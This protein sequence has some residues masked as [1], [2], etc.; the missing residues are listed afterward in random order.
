MSVQ[1]GDQ[2]GCVKVHKMHKNWRSPAFRPI[3]FLPASTSLLFDL[4]VQKY[5][6][7]VGHLRV[8]THDWMQ[9]FTLIQSDFEWRALM[10]Q[11]QPVLFDS[12][13]PVRPL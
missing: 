9:D 5:T 13:R 2:F 10:P 1:R 7:I 6:R 12:T 3:R 4:S 11:P 8:S